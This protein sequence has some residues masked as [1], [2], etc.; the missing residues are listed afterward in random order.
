MF[1]LFYG[2]FLGAWVQVS[3]NFII[4]L[5]R[6]CILEWKIEWKTSLYKIGQQKHVS[7]LH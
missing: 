7:F 4:L 5:K 1:L 3:K 6:C 2:A